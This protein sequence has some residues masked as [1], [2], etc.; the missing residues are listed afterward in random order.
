M[1]KMLTLA[2]VLFIATALTAAP[3]AVPSAAWGSPDATLQQGGELELLDQFALT[4]PLGITASGALAAP[5]APDSLDSLGTLTQVGALESSIILDIIVQGNY[6][7]AGFASTLVV[8]DISD[9]ANLT[10]VA[11]LRLGGEIV[12][13][14][15]M[16]D[17]LYISS[18]NYTEL[19]SNET[20]LWIVDISN[21]LVPVKAGFYHTAW[22]SALA[23]QDDFAF[24]HTEN[25]LE[26]IDISKPD[27]P[28]RVG[29][30]NSIRGLSDIATSG[31][32]MY[33]AVS[34]F[35]IDPGQGIMVFDIS[36]PAQPV[37]AGQ[38]LHAMAS[39]LSSSYLE[40]SNSTLFYVV[41][42]PRAGFSEFRV[43]DISSPATPALVGSLYNHASSPGLTQSGDSVYLAIS[44]FS[45]DGFQIIDVSD[46]ARPTL[47]G[48][49]GED[50]SGYLTDITGIS[51]AG[52]HVFLSHPAEVQSIDVTAPTSPILLDTLE[53]PL[54]YPRRFAVSGDYAYIIDGGLRI[55]DISNPN[56]PVI[57]GQFPTTGELTDVEVDGNMVTLTEADYAYFVDV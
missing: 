47:I 54:E 8:I 9:P 46:P 30:L 45:L 28:V 44:K 53:N 57:V 35:E 2:L 40:V 16:L 41:S 22:T 17:F 37:Y 15:A 26:I 19:P 39:S 5:S 21:P 1:N 14:V 55:A 3:L 43:L 23:V 25:G 24:L 7:Y 56:Q 18:T 12:E 6:A 49:Y 51:A 36:D 42:Y 31:D 20:G 4:D 48:E 11:S 38:Y 33:I 10:R 13:I 29:M 27:N 50:R 34:F 52:G 32:N